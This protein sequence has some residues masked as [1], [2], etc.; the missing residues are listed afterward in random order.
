MFYMWEN[1]TYCSSLQTG[2]CE[3]QFNEE[4]IKSPQANTSI[5]DIPLN[6]SLQL[7]TIKFFVPQCSVQN[8][9]IDSGSTNCLID[10]KYFQSI[11]LSPGI[12]EVVKTRMSIKSIN[13]QSTTVRK[14]IKL[15]FKIG[16]FSWTFDFFVVNSLPFPIILG[17]NFMQK[18][19]MNLDFSSNTINFKFNKDVDIQMSEI[20]VRQSQP[21]NTLLLELT[22]ANK[23][24]SQETDAFLR[25]IKDN[26]PSVITKRIGQARVSPY[27]IHCSTD[28]P[29]C[30][31]PYP[32]PPDRLNAMRK[33]TD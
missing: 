24:H 17:V 21:N 1:W 13:G 28:K 5:S 2:K 25:E 16:N 22:E 29:I 4:V 30:S 23:I 31:P 18:S 9:L 26:F 10:N 27:H 12:R 7:P 33:I 20:F 11:K 19:R 6:F 14:L 15:H 3:R 32:V 8:A